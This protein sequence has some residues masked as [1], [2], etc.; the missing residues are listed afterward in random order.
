MF[1]ISKKKKENFFFS[2]LKF[3]LKNLQ[4]ARILIACAQQNGQQLTGCWDMVLTT[5]QHLV[6]ILNM[7]PISATNF[8]T[9]NDSSAQTNSGNIISTTILSSELPDLVKFFHLKLYNH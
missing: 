2:F 5:F 9:G 4:V 3:S 1:E 8:R 6:W 7:K